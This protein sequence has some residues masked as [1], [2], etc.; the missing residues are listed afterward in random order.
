MLCF[1]SC[2]KLTQFRLALQIDIIHSPSLYRFLMHQPKTNLLIAA[3]IPVYNTEKYLEDCINSILSQTYQKFDIYIINDASTD[4]SKDILQKFAL[5][6]PRIHLF[7]QHTNS[8][9]SKARNYALELIERENKHDVICFIDS[10]D[11]VAKDYFDSISQNFAAIETEC[12]IV[13]YKEFNKNTKM[14]VKRKTYTQLQLNQDD[15]YHFCFGLGGFSQKD[16]CSISSSLWNMSFKSQPIKGI[17]FDEKISTAEDQDYILKCLA[18][19]KKLNIDDNIY[20]FYRIRNSSLTNTN[21]IRISDIDVFLNWIKQNYKMSHACR[22][23]VEHLAF[24]NFWR[25]VRSAANEKKLLSFW[26]ELKARLLVME[27]TFV[28]TE[29]QSRQSK[30]RIFIFKL[31]KFALYSYFKLT[32]K[33]TAHSKI[34]A[35][36]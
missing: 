4:K 32:K 3:I 27:R 26:N 12:L 8:G 34:N 29:L 11:L 10:D 16:F 20:Y 30:K 36:D 14:P 35:F 31:G 19:I 2:I 33:S 24:Q 9:V 1:T 13:G 17:R 21:R 18:K 22:E 28:T 5:K 7:N 15:A 25:A 6:D 23:V